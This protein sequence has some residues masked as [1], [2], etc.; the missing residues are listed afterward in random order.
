MAIYDVD[1]IRESE[2]ME[3]ET[4]SNDILDNMLEACDQML[5][6][7]D[8]VDEGARTRYVDRLANRNKKLE[9]MKS[10]A[11]SKKTIDRIDDEIAKNNKKAVEVGIADVSSWNPD[12]RSWRYKDAET[13]S[14]RI[15]NSRHTLE[16]ESK[17]GK[18][19]YKEKYG[20]PKG[21]D[22]MGN[23]KPGM[24]LAAQEKKK[25]IKET[26]LTILSVLDEI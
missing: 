20:G 19:A 4:D 24:V 13:V 7:L 18:N 26:C 5:T 10:A 15:H 9:I 1:A 14:D 6:A 17:A 2:L 25:H 22:I 23:K 16:K 21:E 8:I 12:N 3:A 11:S